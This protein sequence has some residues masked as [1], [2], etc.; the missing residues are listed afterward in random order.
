MVD[1]TEKRN[2]V[3]NRRNGKTNNLRID[4]SSGISNKNNNKKEQSTT[5]PST[6]ASTPTPRTP[7]T[8][9]NVRGSRDL[10][11][12]GEQMTP[13]SQVAKLPQAGGGLP[14]FITQTD[15]NGNA[16]TPRSNDAIQGA[17]IR[18][19]S[20]P[21]TKFNNN[22]NNGDDSS[23]D[24]NEFDDPCEAIFENL[25]AMCCC[26]MD[27]HH[28]KLQGVA[29]VDTDCPVKLLGQ[30]HPDDVGKPC[31][32]LDLD[33]TLVHSSFRAVPNADFVIPVRVSC[34]NKKKLV[35]TLCPS[36]SLP[37]WSKLS[38]F[39]HHILPPNF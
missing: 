28:M 38:L 21:G 32:V 33:E 7:S 4:T 18:R 37:Q 11:S 29:T 16:T 39:S 19:S 26:L 12:P 5:T 17:R 23:D 8:K 27:D 2:D 25:R 36:L 22:N 9:Q 3:K 31:L 14:D 13:I 24:S 15:A 1:G 20:G 30:H 10:R 6:V 35:H 34:L